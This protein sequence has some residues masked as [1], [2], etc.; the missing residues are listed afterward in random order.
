MKHILDTL[1]PIL[2]LRAGM[3]SMRND[4]ELLT[5]FLA[6]ANGCGLESLDNTTGKLIES[7][8]VTRYPDHFQ[9]GSGLEGLKELVSAL[10]NGLD[11][12]KKKFDNKKLMP[13]LA[14][15]GYDLDVELKK[16]Y[17][18]KAWYNDKTETGKVVNAT[19]LAKLVGDIK[20]SADIIPKVS[21]A[22][23]A[24]GSVI[25]SNLKDTQAYI[26]KALA[27]V[28]KGE[29]LK[30]PDQAALTKFANEQ[31][32]IFKPL[33]EKLDAQSPSIKAG[34]A[35]ADIKLSKDQCIALGAEMIRVLDWIRGKVDESEPFYD[36]A[37]GQNEFKNIEGADDN[38]AMGTLLYGYFYW[39]TSMGAN[40][41]LL[42]EAGKLM[43][44]SILAMESMIVTALK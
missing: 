41:R 19:E 11:G 25:D 43:K 16:T 26:D 7:G 2:D 24:Y 18:N 9:V 37:P 33:L 15:A 28:K 35:A 36:E 34:T 44:S 5:G 12:L 42:M 10:K 40:E 23:T 3:E 4:V 39:E 27:A 21:G 8:L 6:H 29:K 38:D 20:T 22:L 14:K 1:T 30:N 31:I 13:I 17:A 32:A